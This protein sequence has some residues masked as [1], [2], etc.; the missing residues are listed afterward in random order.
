LDNTGYTVSAQLTE[1]ESRLLMRMAL[2]QALNDLESG[3]S[4]YKA[5]ILEAETE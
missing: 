4:K 3:K 2:K 5:T 1:P